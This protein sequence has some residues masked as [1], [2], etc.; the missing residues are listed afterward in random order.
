MHFLVLKKKYLLTIGL[1]ILAVLIMLI[2]NSESTNVISAKDNIPI[3]SVQTDEKKVAITFDSAWDD[4]DLTDVLKALNDY[5]CKAT[6]FVVGD[7]VEKYS[8][9]VDEMYKAG[10]EIANHSD[11]HPHPN[12]LSREE[13]IKEMDE[14]DKKIK[15]ITGQKQVLFRAPY[16]EYNNLLVQTCKDTGRFCIQWDCDSLDWKGLTSDEITKRVVS[17]V[18]NGS[19]ILLHNGAPNTAKALPNLLCELK[20]MGYKFVTV[21]ELI[22]KDNYYIDHTGMQIPK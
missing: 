18:K 11:T 20:N 17:K 7:F 19:I 4:A 21:S 6:F 3:Y 15:E 14:C 1:L 12:S 9:R 2:N 13:M 8:S 10:H 22:Y 16:G 5:E